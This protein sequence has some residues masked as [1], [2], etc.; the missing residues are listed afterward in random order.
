MF[1][2]SARCHAAA[3]EA[4]GEVAAGGRE[5]RAAEILA[6]VSLPRGWFSLRQLGGKGD[7]FFPASAATATDI[8]STALFYFPDAG[9]LAGVPAAVVLLSIP[10][11]RSGASS[12]GMAGGGAPPYGS[13]TSAR[14]LG[15]AAFFACP[16]PGPVREAL[17]RTFDRSPARSAD[18]A[19]V[20]SIVSDFDRPDGKLYFATDGDF[21]ALS[22]DPAAL[23]ACRGLIASGRLP[24]EALPPSPPGD[25]AAYLKAFPRRIFEHDDPAGALPGALRTPVVRTVAGRLERAGAVLRLPGGRYELSIEAEAAGGGL[26]AEWVRQV[27]EAPR[28][29]AER[30]VGYAG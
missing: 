10:E 11:T 12:G 25:G 14:R 20:F 15:R 4:A 13:R 26:L 18:G 5:D 2:V 19:E 6:A 8:I 9:N 21:A 28:G 23:A 1:S 24:A 30:A 7:E 3:H 22:D 17:R 16:D 27:R 29:T